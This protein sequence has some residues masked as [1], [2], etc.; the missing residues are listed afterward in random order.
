M[1]AKSLKPITCA[2]CPRIFQPLASRTKY[3]SLECAGRSRRKLKPDKEAKYTDTI[4]GDV[5]TIQY[6][7]DRQPRNEK[8][9]IA[10]SGADT[11]EWVVD[12]WE[13]KAWEGY[14]KNNNG[15]L[16][17]KT[18]WACRAKFKRNNE[19]QA[20]KALIDGLFR[21]AKKASPKVRKVRPPKSGVALVFGVYDAHV[22]LLADGR[23]TL[24]VNYNLE[25]ARADFILAS[26]K[27]ISRACSQG[28]I[29]KIYYIVG[30]D[31]MHVDSRSN[32]TFNATIQ[33]V[34]TRHFHM[35]EIVEYMTRGQVDRL[36]SI[37]PVEVI[38]MPGNHDEMSAM[39]LMRAIAAFFHAD[40]RIECDLEPSKFKYRQWGTNLMGFTHSNLPNKSYK[41]LPQQ[42]AAQQRE[43]WAECVF[44]MWF[45]GH[46]HTRTTDESYGV[47]VERHPS[48]CPASYWSS[49]Q[50]YV[51]NKR[52]VIAHLLDKSE[53]P[54]GRYQY[55]F[56]E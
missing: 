50:G 9:L 22:G 45:C 25:R 52:G 39:S 12:V 5:R 49:S 8:E 48:L 28:P 3:C 51:G 40:G 41:G 14:A 47:T 13:A 16:I 23:E 2:Q 55:L 33:D 6:T 20:T 38:G 4:E 35:T 19:Y 32:T 11:T 43:A 1:P 29:E 10:Q 15:E 24:E 27:V 34:D 7:T 54:I 42:M 46:M 44:K 26:D 30:N 21:A 17:S 53:G 56:A 37:C 31:L 36:G 18:L